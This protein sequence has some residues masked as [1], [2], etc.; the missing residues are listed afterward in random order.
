MGP[1]NRHTTLM[2]VLSRCSSS[3]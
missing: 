3:S 2:L 1:V